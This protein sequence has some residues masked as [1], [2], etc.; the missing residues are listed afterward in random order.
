MG[1]WQR[2]RVF[3]IDGH[4]IYRRG[5]AACIATIAEAVGIGDA[6][7]VEAA[8]KDDRLSEATIL[9]VDHDLPGARTLIR[10]LRERDDV[11]IIV[12]S[13]SLGDAEMMASIQAGARGFL[14]KD[15]LTP[16]ALASS[17]RTAR[18]GAGVIG[19]ELL[20]DLLEGIS[21][22]GRGG[23]EPNGS[24]LGRLTA[25]ERNVLRLIAEG[26]PTREVAERLSYS[27]RT[28]K[29]VVHDITTKLDARSRSQAVA[30]AVREGLI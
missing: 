6:A 3:V 16:E 29:N 8:R 7:S 22:A 2:A 10:E 15:T 26:C 19:P 24:S 17:I 9:L 11:T 12:C 13:Q 30:H 25:R 18:N 1:G 23:L 20:G 21:R 5:I 14:S 4:A 27:E 28:I